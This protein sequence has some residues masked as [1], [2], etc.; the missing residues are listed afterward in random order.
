MTPPRSVPAPLQ[1]REIADRAR[2]YLAKSIVEVDYYRIRQRMFFPVPASEFP[3]QLSLVRGL[4]NYPFGI[5]LLWELENRILSLG[6]HAEINGHKPAGIAAKRDL[7]GLC[8][9]R[10]FR[11]V[12]KPDL[13]SSHLTRILVQALGWKWLPRES[14]RKIRHQLGLLVED[15]LTHPFALP[16]NNVKDL[17]EQGFRISNIPVIGAMGLSIAAQ[18]CRHPEAAHLTRRAETMAMTWLEWGMRGH[19]E[20]VSYDGYTADFLMDWAGGCP[21]SIRDRFLS[22]PRLRQII[23]E[24]ALLGAPTQPENLAPIGDVEPREMP[25]HYSFASKYLAV[26]PDLPLPWP[27]N[28]PALV[29]GRCHPLCFHAKIPAFG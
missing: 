9:W 24:I 27:E 28:L 4:P 6:W 20:G 29:R 5:W 26:F 25:F 11:Q 15:G 23:D 10:R 7:E 22:H 1:R 14:G 13:C 21:S 2:R 12:D 18:A 16:A 19:V 8:Q 17:L 3:E